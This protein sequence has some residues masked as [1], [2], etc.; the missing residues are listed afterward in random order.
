MNTHLLA[1]QLMAAQGVLGAFDTLYHHEFTEGLPHR[2][3]ARKELSIHA[4]RAIIYSAL[5]VGLSFWKW[6]GLWAVILFIVFGVEIVLTL[7]DFV[8]EDKTR[9]LPATERVTH[10]I[11]A[12][13]GGAFITLLALSLPSWLSAPTAMVFES[14]GLLSFFLALCGIGVGLSG[15]R[16]AFAAWRLTTNQRAE[17]VLPSIDF[18]AS[19][20]SVLVTGGT[21]FIGKLLIQSLLENGKLVTVLTRN[22]KQAAWQFDGKVRCISNMSVLPTTH[23]I[24]VMINLA[25]ARV[26]G[27]RWTTARKSF[28]RQSRIGLTQNLV[29]WIANAKHKPRL[30]IS[31]SAIGYYG[32]QQEGDDTNLTEASPAQA[33][34]MSELC[35]DWEGA[36]HQARADGVRV[37]VMRLGLVLGDHGSLS[38]MLL[39]IRICLGGPLGSGKQWLSWI[40]V[41]DVV[42]GIAHLWNMPG[43]AGLI[44]QAADAYNFTAPETVTQKQFSQVAATVIHRPCGFPTPGFPLRFAFGEQADLLLAGQRVIPAKLLAE[45]FSFSFPE[46]RIALENLT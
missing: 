39:P 26:L 28:L 2:S 30:L 37:I 8:V 25:G 9:L 36:A 44:S 32:I 20:E 14:Q 13:N 45:G 22:P 21:G 17:K 38:M 29:H 16:D 19:G 31:A 3:S 18:G 41:H 43:E 12:I 27:W 46:L 35:Q 11:L 5:F 15:V 7:W 42:R 6:H 10:T 24:D 33:I 23:V 1:L 40:H 4:G 34:F